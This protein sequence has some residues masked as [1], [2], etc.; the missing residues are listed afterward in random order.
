MPRIRS[1]HPDICNDDDVAGLS[2]YAF[3]TWVMLWTHLDDK[4]RGIDNAKLWAGVL[5]P[6]NDK[7]TAERVERDLA[8]LEASNL[9]IRYEVDGRR[10][11]SAKPS[12]WAE[13]QKPQKPTPSKLPPIPTTRLALGQLP[14]GVEGCRSGAEG[15]CETEPDRPPTLAETIA[16]KGARGE[17]HVIG[18]AS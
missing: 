2:P 10:Y 11:L 16:A 5:Y 17:L 7:M 15:V 3:R 8:E 12:S 1:V 14:T 6:L 18:E 4:G 13:R 9:L